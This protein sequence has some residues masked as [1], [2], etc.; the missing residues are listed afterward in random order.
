MLV[1]L[2]ADSACPACVVLMFA[3][4]VD[5]KLHSGCLVGCFAQGALSQARIACTDVMVWLL[6][7]MF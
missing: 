2:C 6:R 4:C 1:W 7:S 3:M 5:C